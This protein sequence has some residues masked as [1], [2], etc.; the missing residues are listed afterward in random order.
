VSE[1]GFDVITP[2]NDCHDDQPVAVS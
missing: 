2:P 1:A